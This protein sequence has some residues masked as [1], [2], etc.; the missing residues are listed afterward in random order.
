MNIIPFFI[1]DNVYSI[2]IIDKTNYEYYNLVLEKLNICSTNFI[3]NNYETLSYESLSESGYI[4]CFI[5]NTSNSI[6]FSSLIIDLECVDIKNKITNTELINNAISISLLCS[7]MKKRIPKLTY[8]FVQYVIYNIIPL[9]KP[10]KRVLLYVAKG[11]ENQQA[12][13]FYQ[14]LGF[15]L[16]EN[17]I[18]ILSITQNKGGTKRKRRIKRRNKTRHYK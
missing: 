16:N 5:T 14:K 15:V 9:Y 7:D 11:K 1:E 6:I 4:G 17:N 13:S 3:S 2:H 18:M 12:I 10:I 8:L